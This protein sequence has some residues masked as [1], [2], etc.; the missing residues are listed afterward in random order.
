MT[1]MIMDHYSSANRMLLREARE[2]FMF[3]AA[4]SESFINHVDPEAAIKYYR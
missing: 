4:I 2:K 1:K 3:A